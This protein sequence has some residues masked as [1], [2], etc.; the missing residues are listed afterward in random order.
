[1]P[2]H[3]LVKCPAAAYS[4][5]KK[6]RRWTWLRQPKKAAGFGLQKKSFLVFDQAG[7]PGIRTLRAGIGMAKR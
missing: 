6:P 3:P 7:L 4:G 1:M 2:D 5:S